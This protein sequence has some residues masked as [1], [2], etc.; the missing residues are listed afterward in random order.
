MP[1]AFGISIRQYGLTEAVR[2]LDPRIAER[3]L[4]KGLE[5]GAKYALTVVQAQ[6][7][8]RARG[9]GTYKGDWHIERLGPD[10]YAVVNDDSGGYAKYVAGRT[11]TT[12][13]FRGANERFMRKIKRETSP[14]VRRLIAQAVFEAYR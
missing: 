5:Q 8:V 12:R 14:Q 6:S 1:E 4:G 13:P 2:K 7:R 11:Q 3:A 9:G 10:T